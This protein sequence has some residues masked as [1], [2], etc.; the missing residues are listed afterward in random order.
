MQF[1]HT[2][3]RMTLQ[4][5]RQTKMTSLFFIFGMTLSMLMVS[6]GI[7]FVSELLAAQRAK[8]KAMPPNGEQ[9]GFYRPGEEGLEFETTLQLFA[10]LG[11]GSGVIVN[12]LML[13]LDQSEVNTFH[14]VSAELM[15]LLQEINEEGKTLLL[16]T[17]DEKVANCAKKR[18]YIEDGKSRPRTILTA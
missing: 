7:S 16:V 14:S 10:G 1:I 17:H 12:H 8:E 4:R 9:F 5:I 15:G 18:L 13:H 6:I 3:I 2:T 11:S